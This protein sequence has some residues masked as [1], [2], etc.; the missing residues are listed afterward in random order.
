M[1]TRTNGHFLTFFRE[2]SFGAIRVG[3]YYSHV[4]ISDER[5]WE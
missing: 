5:T 1:I 2:I 3:S 4:N